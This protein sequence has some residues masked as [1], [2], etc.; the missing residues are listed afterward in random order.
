MIRIGVR[1]VLATA[2]VLGAGQMALGATAA[3]FLQAATPPAFRAGNT[4]PRLTRWGWVLPADARIELAKNW[5]YTL[6]L[7]DAD[8]G[9]LADLADPNS[10]TSKLAAL[11]TANPK[12]YPVSVVAGAPLFDQGFLNSL[13]SSTWCVA[14]DGTKVWSP[15]APD[16]AM[17]QAATCAVNWFKQ[18]QAKAPV[19][20]ILNG[21]EYGMQYLGDDG[22]AWAK[23]PKVVQAKGNLSWDTYNSQKKAH[24]E[25]IISNAFRAACPNRSLYLYYYADGSGRRGTAPYY[26]GRKTNIGTWDVWY[27]DFAY[28]KQVTDLPASCSYYLIYNTGFTGDIDM[29]TYTLNGA[30]QHIALGTPLSYNWLTGGCSVSGTDNMADLDLYEGFL[31]CNYTAGMIGGVAVYYDLPTGGFSGDLGSVAPNWLQQIMVLAQVHGIFSNLENFLRQGDLLPGPQM[32]RWSKAFPAYE[33]PTGDANARVLVRKLRSSNTWLV[34]AWAASGT[35]RQVTV[36]VPTLGKFT[37]TACRAGAVYEATLQGGHAV[38]ARVDTNASLN[39]QVVNAA[40]A[41]ASKMAKKAH[42]SK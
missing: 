40:A 8:P 2:M 27:R 25:A 41:S 42:V 13:P 4:L 1:I 3:Q 14:A 18:I 19:S 22:A 15:E 7:G 17:Q 12:Q 5:D 29:L 28:M 16:A 24:Q 23:D 11:A 9:T 32:H 37:T 20:I 36:T 35:D 33:F 30:G 6:D 21:G 34:T 38:L 26:G 39:T 10:D 31:K